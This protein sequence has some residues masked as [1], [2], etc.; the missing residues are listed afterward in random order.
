VPS[1]L[2]RR[3]RFGGGDIDCGGTEPIPLF[4]LFDVQRCTSAQNIRHQTAMTWVQ[5]LDHHNRCWE[6]G[7]QGREDLAQGR[8]ATG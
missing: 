3:C 2:A 8:Q 4:R 5:V 6:I 7:R 1:G